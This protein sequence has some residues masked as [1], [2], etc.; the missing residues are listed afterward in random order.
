VILVSCGNNIFFVDLLIEEGELLLI[1]SEKD[2]VIW[3]LN[4]WSR[5][6]INYT[7]LTW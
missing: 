4:C 5:R 6:E 2:G 3:S 7:D 1:T